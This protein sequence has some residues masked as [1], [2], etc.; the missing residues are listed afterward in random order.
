MQIVSGG[1]RG[2]GGGLNLLQFFM[3]TLRKGSGWVGLST[4][5]TTPMRIKSVLHVFCVTT[6]CSG[7]TP[8]YLPC[9]EDQGS[10]NSDYRKVKYRGV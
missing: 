10:E 5:R 7:M 8:E 4:E 2:R 3:S 6:I 9:S 1:A